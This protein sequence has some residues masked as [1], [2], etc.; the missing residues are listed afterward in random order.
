LLQMVTRSG[1]SLQCRIH[2]FQMSSCLRNFAVPEV[3][4]PPNSV[5]TVAIVFWYVVIAAGH[6]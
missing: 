3:T 6:L 2:T 5:D 4:T 1:C